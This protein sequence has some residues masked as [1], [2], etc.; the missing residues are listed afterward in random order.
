MPTNG[1]VRQLQC[2]CGYVAHGD[3]DDELVANVQTHA[4]EEHGMKLSAELIVVLIHTQGAT[5]RRTARQAESQ[6]GPV[7][8]PIERRHR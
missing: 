2:E 6:D 4:D 5:T 7:S 8:P 3:N 1:P